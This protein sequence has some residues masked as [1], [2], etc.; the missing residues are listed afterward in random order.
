MMTKMDFVEG[1]VLCK[2]LQDII[3]QFLV[4]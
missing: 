3:T 1:K 4:V 2:K